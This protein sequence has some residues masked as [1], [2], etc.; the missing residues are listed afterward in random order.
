MRTDQCLLHKA[1]RVEV[2]L[3][4]M[5]AARDK[6]TR[7][8]NQSSSY[9]I[10]PEPGRGSHQ[11]RFSESRLSFGATRGCKCTEPRRGNQ[12]D[13]RSCKSSS[14]PLGVTPHPPF[15]ASRT[16]HLLRAGSCWAESLSPAIIPN[17]TSV[18]IPAMFHHSVAA[19][20]QA[21]CRCTLAS[22]KII[23]RERLCVCGCS[24][25]LK[26]TNT[27]KRSPAEHSPSAAVARRIWRHVRPC[28]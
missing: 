22:T 6:L 14:P 13:S 23:T 27:S 25:G 11:K 17:K 1:Q 20:S 28:Q 10:K 15:C 19:Y 12:R 3:F 8:H 16:P 2:A 9:S 7:L 24:S 18:V 5:I 4:S 26:H 21:H